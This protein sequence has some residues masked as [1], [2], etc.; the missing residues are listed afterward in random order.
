MIS[1]YWGETM[2]QTIE[3]VYDNGVI[4]PLEVVQAENGSRVII[5]F[6]E[7]KQALDHDKQQLLAALAKTKGIWA[8]DDEIAQAFQEL[9]RLPWE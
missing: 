4:K 2:Y 8:D 5:T 1:D 7:S 6:L 9:E 3:G